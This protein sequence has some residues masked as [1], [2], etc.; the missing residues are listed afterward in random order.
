MFQIRKWEK[1]EPHGRGKFFNGV[2]RIKK[3]VPFFEF[4]PFIEIDKLKKY[5][6][7][8]WG[9]GNYSVT[10]RNGKFRSVWRGKV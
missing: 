5:I 1:T 3:E 6:F 7:N 9:A 2:W 4:D 10:F 8:N